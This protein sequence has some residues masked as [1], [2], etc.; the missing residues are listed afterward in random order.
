MCVRGGTIGLSSRSRQK[1]ADTPFVLSLRSI[2]V[3]G[4]IGWR[5]VIDEN[6]NTIMFMWMEITT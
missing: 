2:A 5:S 1:S 3:R 4:S 6:P